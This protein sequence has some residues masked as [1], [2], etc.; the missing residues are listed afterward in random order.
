M[1]PSWVQTPAVANRRDYGPRRF[2]SFL[3][4][5]GG[6]QYGVSGTINGRPGW[7][8]GRLALFR[9]MIVVDVL[10]F[11]DLNFKD[12]GADL[13]RNC[14]VLGKGGVFLARPPPS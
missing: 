13:P 11:V 14:R 8:M 5:S 10:L 1:T 6:G 7:S 4:D 2:H 3:A 9:C 12:S